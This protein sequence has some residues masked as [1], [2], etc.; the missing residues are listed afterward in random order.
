METR[1][2]TGR[3]TG[4]VPGRETGR[5]TGRKGGGN[6]VTWRDEAL[7]CVAWLGFAWLDFT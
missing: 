6:D 3:E 1:A 5:E 4:A 7:R 2:E